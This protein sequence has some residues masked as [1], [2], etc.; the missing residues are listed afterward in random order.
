MIAAS[1]CRSFQPVCA[2][3]QS[4]IEWFISTFFFLRWL[5]FGLPNV[6]PDFWYLSLVNSIGLT[7]VFFFGFSLF[8]DNI[9]RKLSSA[10]SEADHRAR[11]ES[12][13]TRS[14]SQTVGSI[15]AG[16]NV[17][18]EQK[19]DNSPEIREW[20][21]SFFKSPLGQIIIA[22]VGGFL[23]FLDPVLKDRRD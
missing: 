7:A 12:F 13:N 1:G 22:A 8:L 23:A 4:V 20:D 17:S 3:I 9:R 15:Q 16:G 19:I 21:R 2:S 5:W 6:P 14:N 18:I 11:V 10:L